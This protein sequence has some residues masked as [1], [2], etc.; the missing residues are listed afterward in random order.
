MLVLQ[1]IVTWKTQLA[2]C[3]YNEIRKSIAITSFVNF[4]IIIP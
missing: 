4:Q 3:G 1:I 2:S